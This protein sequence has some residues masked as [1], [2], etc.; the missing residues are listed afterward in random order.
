MVK[1]NLGSGPWKAEGF[2]NV[3]IINHPNV[4]IVHNL[5]EVPWPFEDESVGHVHAKNILEHL[6]DLVLTMEE[7]WRILIP[8]GT[9]EIV[10]PYYN[11]TGAFR[12][13]THKQFFTEHTFDYFSV[14]R[15]L[16]HYNYYSK[17]RFE[18][19]GITL[20]PVRRFLRELPRGFLLLLAHNFCLIH[21]ITFLL[22]KPD[23]ETT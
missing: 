9:T 2:L 19:V 18:V 14:N 23:H 1:L 10:V 4:D 7:I 12:D 15:S 8:G 17:C 6:D 20:H 11:C 13:P 16:S 22:H 3:D 5:N 21:A